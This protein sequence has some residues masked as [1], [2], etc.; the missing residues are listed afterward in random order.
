[1]PLKMKSDAKRPPAIAGL[2]HVALRV[3]TLSVAN[4]STRSCW[5]I[6]LN[7]A[8]MRTMFI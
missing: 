8:P 3:A 2:R 7:G 5:A 4:S 6:G 1:M